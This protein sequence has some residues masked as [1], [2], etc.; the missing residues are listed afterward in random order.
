[1][2][3]TRRNRHGAKHVS[4]ADGVRENAMVKPSDFFIG[5]IDF[6]GILVPGAVLLFLDGHW[7]QRALNLHLPSGR[8][9]Q[10]AVFLVGSYVLGHFLLGAGVPLNR[11][12]RIRAGEGGRLYREVSRD[13]S[14]RVKGDAPAPSQAQPEQTTPSPT[15]RVQ[16]KEVSGDTSL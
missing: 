3:L 12:L 8:V 2:T 6:F 15:K 14:L 10:W 5:V 7:L 16:E 13:T 4:N 1:D 11:V 9:E